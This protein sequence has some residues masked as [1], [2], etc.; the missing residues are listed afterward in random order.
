M[1]SVAGWDQVQCW[2]HGKVEKGK[3]IVYIS[4][5][6]WHSELLSVSDRTPQTYE[7]QLSGTREGPTRYYDLIKEERDWSLEMEQ[8]V[9]DF[10]FPL[11]G[12]EQEDSRESETVKRSPFFHAHNNHCILLDIVPPLDTSVWGPPLC[13]DALLTPASQGLAKSSGD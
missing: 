1:T 3:H 12:E 2:E 13:S 10:W 11:S 4:V 5:V 8:G 6:P 7:V 9:V